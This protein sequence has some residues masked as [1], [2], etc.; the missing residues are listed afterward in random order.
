MYIFGWEF[1]TI[2]ELKSMDLVVKAETTSTKAPITIVAV[3]EKSLKA[4]GR[5]PWS[6]ET[7]ARLV[8]EINT[9]TPRVIGLDMF[10]PEE[11]TPDTIASAEEMER[12]VHK[13]LGPDNPQ[14]DDLVR[15]LRETIENRD[16]DSDDELLARAILSAG[17]VVAMHHFFTETD[18][19]IPLYHTE[20]PLYAEP[21]GIVQGM[22]PYPA[23]TTAGGILESI[24]ILSEAAADSGFINIRMDTDGTVRRAP[25]TIYYRGE[26]YPSFALVMAKRFLDAPFERLLLDEYGVV[27][28]ELGNTFIPTDDTGN[29]WIHFL[30]PGG[31]F[32]HISAVDVLEGTADL[33]RLE[34]GIVLVGIT[35]TG[36]GD[37]RVTPVSTVFPG[38]EI[39]ATIIENIISG[40][41][42]TMP[43]WM[44]SVHLLIIVL[45]GLLTGLALLRLGPFI[46]LVLTVLLLTGYFF[47]YRYLL[48][49]QQLNIF[50]IY[51]ALT[52]FAVYTSVTTSKYFAESQKK[53]Y[54]QR[55]FSQY[56]SPAVIKELMDNPARLNLGGEERVL[57][58]MFTDIEGFSLISERMKPE[59]IVTM[60]NEYFT[61]M[62]EIIFAF[63]GTVDKYEGD[64]IMAFFGAPILNQHHARETVRAAYYMQKRLEQLRDKWKKENSPLLHMRIGINTGPMVVGNLGSIQK[65]DYTVMG[66]AVNLASRFEPINKLFGT[67]IIIGN[68]TKMEVEDEFLIRELDFTR[69]PG[70]N[71]PV[72]IYEVLEERNNADALTQKKVKLFAEGRK[73]FLGR[74]FIKAKETFLAILSL[75]EA[76]MPS[77][78]YLKRCEYFI[79]HPPDDSWEGIFDI[80]VK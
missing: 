24:S 53:R 41:M 39:H 2:L 4:I 1:L 22:S 14:G 46:G 71:A 70:R 5:W 21:F 62:T 42:F 67:K 65:M 48:L 28:V 68:E 37:I 77:S 49:E 32:P 12:I 59:E 8:E 74:E 6:R 13:Y 80:L 47:G 27:G 29:L 20:N 15:A 9:G 72:T 31:T 57:T 7:L 34:G 60:L 18:S 69:V 50:I 54:I 17:N 38:V 23:A 43:G 25:L 36:L 64:A 52:L 55:A 76:D 26:Y 73:L 56:L 58:A 16:V 45:L 3:D 11:T 10:F 30:G 79:E 61:V 51:P 40:T 78:V 66:D 44:A 75:D 33:T 63:N 35:A 19:R